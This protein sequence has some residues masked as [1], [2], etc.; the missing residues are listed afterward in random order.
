MA[1]KTVNIGSI[2]KTKEGRRYI[3]V[4]GDHVLK[5]GQFLNLENEKTQLEQVDFALSKEYITEDKA[6][7]RKAQIKSYWNDPVKT[8]KGSFVRSE[9]VIYNITVQSED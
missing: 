7:E 9:S 1:K 2:N 8:D 4:R 6:A 5:D 3:K